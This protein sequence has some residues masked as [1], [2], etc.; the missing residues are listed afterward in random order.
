MLEYLTTMPDE[1]NLKQRAW[2]SHQYGHG[3]VSQAGGAGAV[4]LPLKCCE[5][6]DAL[7]MSG[8]TPVF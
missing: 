3:H 6:F 7:A 1:P 5:S 8:F 2:R 4:V